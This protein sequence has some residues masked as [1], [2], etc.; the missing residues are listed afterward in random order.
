[1]GKR[2]KNIVWT[3]RGGWIILFDGKF[4]VYTWKPSKF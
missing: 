3:G 1:M 4:Q 2:R